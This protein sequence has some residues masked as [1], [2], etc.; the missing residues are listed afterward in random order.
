MVDSPIVVEGASL[1][2]S[3]CCRYRECRRRATPGFCCPSVV[4]IAI[5]VIALA[6]PLSLALALTLAFVVVIRGGADGARGH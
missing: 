1:D 5:R 6:F 4:V 3:R 2:T